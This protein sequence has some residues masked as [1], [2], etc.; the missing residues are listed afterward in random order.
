M[1]VLQKLIIGINLI[2]KLVFV[3]DLD[4]LLSRLILMLTIGWSSYCSIQDSSLG[5][6]LCGQQMNLLLLWLDW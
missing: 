1:R 5:W 4:N 3:Q 2:L 6:L